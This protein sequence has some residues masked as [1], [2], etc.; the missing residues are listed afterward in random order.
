MRNDDVE[1]LLDIYLSGAQID[2]QCTSDNVP[3]YKVKESHILNNLQEKITQFMTFANAS[4]RC[5]NVSFIVTSIDENFPK[6]SDI[7]SLLLYS[8]SDGCLKL[9]NPPSKPNKPVVK[10]VTGSNATLSCT[11]NIPEDENYDNLIILISEQSTSTTSTDSWK[12]QIHKFDGAKDIIVNNLQ[13]NTSYHLKVV[14]EY[15]YG[16]SE[17]SEIC[18]IQ[19]KFVLDKPG[20]PRVRHK[21]QSTFV[22]E[23]DEP[24]QTWH[25]QVPVP[26]IQ[27]YKIYTKIMTENSESSESIS[28]TENNTSKDNIE[29]VLGNTYTF[30]VVAVSESG[31]SKPSEESDPYTVD[32]IESATALSDYVGK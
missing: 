2:S 21:N 7:S 29:L 28:E 22:L 16:A 24:P 30:T 1:H 17:E 8:K 5:E 18:A 6:T 10:D 15:K 25:M 31:D 13:P 4:K 11:W 14:A 26:V 23:W 20:K 3:W 9:F 32:Y 27:R 12:Q 19:T